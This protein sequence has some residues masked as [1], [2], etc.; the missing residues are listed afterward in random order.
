MEVAGNTM[1]DTENGIEANEEQRTNAAGRADHQEGC[2]IGLDVVGIGD[3][4]GGI[5]VSGIL[6]TPEEARELREAGLGVPRKW[7]PGSTYPGLRTVR[8]AIPKSRVVFREIGARR[9]N[10]LLRSMGGRQRTLAWAN[11]E[12]I[13]ALMASGFDCKVAIAG[14]L[15]D[16][17]YLERRLRKAGLSV[18][19]RQMADAGGDIA[20]AAASYLSHARLFPS[21][22]RLAKR[23]RFRFPAG[24]R[25][26]VQAGR[27]FVSR[28]G[29]ES[30]PD[31]AK[32][33]FRTADEVLGRSPADR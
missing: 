4:F 25:N 15:G 21:R 6:V 1:S 22:K 19:L 7:T 13:E 12:C 16:R 24:A 17:E 20:V 23:F 18:E 32:M 30:L 2:W 9:Y 8:G 27:L 11:A 31:V 14:D 28:H 10:E 3:F 26:V 5:V 33:D 29:R